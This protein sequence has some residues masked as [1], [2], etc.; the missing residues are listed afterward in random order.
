MNKLRSAVLPTAPTI[1]EL[2]PRYVEAGWWRSGPVACPIEAGAARHPLSAA[3]VD[4]Y[5]SFTYAELDDSAGR[6]RAW[7]SRV[8]VGPGEALVA[9]VPNWFESVALYHAA[10]RHGAVMVPL[11]THAREAELRHAVHATGCRAVA[12]PPSHLQMARNLVAVSELETVGVIERVADP[13]QPTP[14]RGVESIPGSVASA[15]AVAVVIY[16]SGSTAEPKGAIHTHNTLGAA[17]RNLSWCLELS[18]AD[19][20]YVPGPIAHIGG[21]MHGLHMAF[22]VGAKVVLEDR[23]DPER[24]VDRITREGVTVLGGAPVFPEGVVRAFESRQNCPLR[25]VSTG[26]AA[27][28]ESLGDRVRTVLGARFVRTYGS[29]ECPFASGSLPLDTATEVD[30]DDGALMPGVEGRIRGGGESGELMLRSASM[31]QG[32]VDPAQNRAALEAGWFLTGDLAALA[33]QR[34]KVTGRLKAIAIR[35]GENISLDEVERTLEGWPE[36]A[37]VSAFAVPDDQTGQRVVVAVVPAP[38]AAPT[39]SGMVDYLRRRGLAAQKYP[40][41]VVCF[42][43]FPRLASGKVDRRAVANEASSRPTTFRRG[44]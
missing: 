35:N 33:S 11:S 42:D 13:L 39:Y 41:K 7:L 36:A 20:V 18:A 44:R 16:T 17:N 24:A 15:A 40:E 3:V 10:L 30:R 32:Y 23:W 27:I 1:T 22:D 38:G 31:F 5:G 8:A 21:L 6:A 37:A 2:G 19:V 4:P 12:V 28:A 34:V 14:I 26:G 9:V 43:E 25:V 29:T